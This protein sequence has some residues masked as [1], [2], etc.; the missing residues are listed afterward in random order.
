MLCQRCRD[1]WAQIEVLTLNHAESRVRFALYQL[2]Q[3]RGVQTSRGVKIQLRITHQEL[4]GLTG[5]SRETATRALSNLQNEGLVKVETR[6]FLIPDPEKIVDGN[7]P[8]RQD[9]GLTG[10]QVRTQRVNTALSGSVH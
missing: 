2:C 10:P 9:G 5:I 4:A 7:K 3:S 6:R 8:V 1:A